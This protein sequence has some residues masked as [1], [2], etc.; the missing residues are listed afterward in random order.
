MPQL[1]EMSMK[2]GSELQAI[3]DSERMNILIRHGLLAGLDVEPP[4][5][6]SVTFTSDIVPASACDNT[7]ASLSSSRTVAEHQ[8][9]QTRR[10]ISQGTSCSIRQSGA[11]DAST[12][13]SRS[14]SP[15][16]LTIS[17]EEYFGE[18][19]D[20]MRDEGCNPSYF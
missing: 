20:H 11:R 12:G 1:N 8:T 14:G 5:S 6:S 4:A 18:V 10:Q 16:G 13:R 7:C 2:R 17:I 15:L 9:R 3:L 19:D